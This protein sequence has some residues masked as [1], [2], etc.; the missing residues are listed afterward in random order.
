MI[1]RM[2]ALIMRSITG[3]K[4]ETAKNVGQSCGIIDLEK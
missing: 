1:F 3:D 4:G 2:I